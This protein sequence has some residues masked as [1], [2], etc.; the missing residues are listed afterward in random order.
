[1][2]QLW[3]SPPLF[4]QGRF[5]LF[6]LKKLQLLWLSSEFSKQINVNGHCCVWMQEAVKAV[7]ELQL[8]RRPKLVLKEIIIVFIL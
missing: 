3:Q 2:Q 6:L 4:P 5:D 8:G 7:E 1:M